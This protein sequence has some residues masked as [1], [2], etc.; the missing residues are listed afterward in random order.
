MVN[1]K[2]GRPIRAR[3]EMPHRPEAPHIS[4]ASSQ[5]PGINL[6]HAGRRCCGSPLPSAHGRPGE[7]PSPPPPRGPS[8]PPVLLA[9]RSGLCSR[10]LPG[11]PF[12][13]AFQRQNNQ[14]F[15]CARA[16]GGERPAARKLLAG[17]NARAPGGAA[18]AA[19]APRLAQGERRAGRRLLRRPPP[20]SSKS[21]FPLG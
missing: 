14:P 9:P 13:L 8:R 10:G 17:G 12:K 4:C 20:W 3:R 6:N 5:W 16:S 21:S 1:F 7:P 19:A 15:P 18:L 11:L 2:C